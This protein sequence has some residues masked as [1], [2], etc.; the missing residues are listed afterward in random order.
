MTRPDCVLKIHRSELFHFNYFFKNLK[1]GKGAVELRLWEVFLKVNCSWR[2]ELT[3]LDWFGWLP[4]LFFFSPK[5]VYPLRCNP[6]VSALWRHLSAQGCNVRSKGLQASL[7]SSDPVLPPAS[8]G[9]GCSY[10]DVLKLHS[11]PSH[12]LLFS[13][14]PSCPLSNSVHHPF[15]TPAWGAPT[16]SRRLVIQLVSVET[17]VPSPAQWVKDLA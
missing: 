10:S 7:P 6:W 4:C 12:L 3:L 1:G 8:L 5:L 16:G 15:K 13:Q 2:L 11:A 9:L 17:P 14:F